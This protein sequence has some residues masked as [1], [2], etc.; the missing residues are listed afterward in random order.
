VQLQNEKK[1]L[2]MNQR[3]PEDKK[4]SMVQTLLDESKERVNQLL[5]ENR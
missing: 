4:L 1:M 2:R 5:V 3:G